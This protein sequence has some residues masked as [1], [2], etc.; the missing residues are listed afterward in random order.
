MSIK[1]KH[2]KRILERDGY[3]CQKCN[4]PQELHVHHIVMVADD[5]LDEDENL[6]TLCGGCHLE[7]HL[8]EQIN[9]ISFEEWLKIPI[10]NCF[11]AWYNSLKQTD[12]SQMTG[13]QVLSLLDKFYDFVKIDRDMVASSANIHCS[14]RKQPRR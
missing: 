12:L 3:K 2:R 4:S 11:M 8:S 7:W 13:E 1:A 6:I 14:G 5:G 10:Y 9:N